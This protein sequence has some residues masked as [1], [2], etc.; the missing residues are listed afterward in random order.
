MKSII[1]NRAFAGQRVTGQQRY[2]REVARRLEAS[3]DYRSAEP[4]GFW[5]RSTLRTWAWVQIVLPFLAR[6][7]VV[8]S[9][10]SRAPLWCR[11]HVLVVHDLFV[12]THP[13]WY[14]RRYIW[15]HAP[16]LRAQLR[17]AA[18]VVAVSRPV[19]DELAAYRTDPVEV[20]PNAPSDV[21][22]ERPDGPDDEALTAR[23]LVADGYLLAVGSKDP[24]KNLPR[25]AAAYGR[26][27]AEDRRAFP[28]VV[29]GAAN[30]IFADEALEWP[31]GKVD[32]GYVTDQELRQLYRHAR[33]VVFV[34]L[35]EGFGLPLVE[36]AAAGSRGLLASDIPVFRWI[37]GD[38][39]R[40]VDP[41]SVDDVAAALRGEI[42]DPQKL[43]PNVER[44]SWDRTAR[45]VDDSCERVVVH[46]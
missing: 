41:L 5:A 46:G 1:V 14:S 13:E 19:A 44:F 12:L 2:A 6:G 29:V 10:T 25:L 36:A 27:T 34:S 45:V 15:T 21:F 3:S 30:A 17:S 11:R 31:E 26:L 8:L 23:G 33:C 9:M 20:A 37:G 16:L 24:R 28:L 38:T 7:S 32:A 40:Y 22:F 39:V 4:V 35:A 18:A 43:E 42:D